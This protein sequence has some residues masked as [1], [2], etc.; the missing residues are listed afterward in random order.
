MKNLVEFGRYSEQRQSNF[1]IRL[2]TP[3]NITKDDSAGG[4]YWIRSTSG[5]SGSYRLND[6][7]IIAEKLN[8]LIIDHNSTPHENSKKMYRRNIEILQGYKGFDFSIWRPNAELKF[9]PKPKHPILVKNIPIQILPNHVFSYKEKD[10]QKIGGIIFVTWLEGFKRG[11]LG[12]FSDTLFRYLSDNY[13]TSFSIEPKFC[14]AVDAVS[15]Q[16][17]GYH[18]ILSGEI[19]P[20]LEPTIDILKKYIN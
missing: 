14:L 19:Q 17:V 8:D 6:S 2:Q 20:L 1:A 9:L 4:D 5:I 7:K 15:K 18:Q 10:E 3:K 12:V 11:D 13:T 16:S